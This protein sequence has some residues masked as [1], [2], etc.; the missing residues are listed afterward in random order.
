MNRE[1][2]LVHLTQDPVRVKSRL[3]WDWLIGVDI[4]HERP[5]VNFQFDIQNL[6][7]EERLFNFLSVFSGT[8]VIRPRSFSARLRYN[9]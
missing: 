5:R 7:D 9:F 8:H 6:T 1:L 4:P 2:E 3:V